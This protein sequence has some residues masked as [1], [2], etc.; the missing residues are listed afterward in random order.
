ME[1]EC[2]AW[3]LEGTAHLRTAH[4]WAA[5]MQCVD[6]DVG[7]SPDSLVAFMGSPVPKMRLISR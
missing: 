5:R 3:L 6:G 1:E 4:P 2:G 7:G